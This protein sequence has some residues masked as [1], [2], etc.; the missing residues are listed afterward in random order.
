MRTHDL[1]KTRARMT[2]FGYAPVSEETSEW[3]R[4]I[5]YRGPDDLVIGFEER[6]ENSPLLADREALAS[7]RSGPPRMADLPPLPDGLHYLSRVIRRVADVTKMG[8]FYED[9]M[10][11]ERRGHEGASELF[12]LGDA[13]TLEI[14]P[15]G[16]PRPEPA[17][18]AERPDSYILRIHGFEDA[19]AGLEARGARFNGE[20]I[21][22]SGNTRLRYIPDPE[23]HL[24]GIEERGTERHWLE[25]VE[26]DTRWRA[27][28]PEWEPPAA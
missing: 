18:R 23:G 22:W 11:F 8:A 12:S 10:G 21:V 2:S 13:V 17:D 19:V 6:D 3:G 26:A 5:F 27:R 16:I 20:L 25:D 24:N 14:A 15:G 7:W 9:V 1:A 4:T 28:H